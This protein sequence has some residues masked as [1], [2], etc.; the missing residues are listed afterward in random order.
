MLAWPD[1]RYIV[2]VRMLWGLTAKLIGSETMSA[3]VGI[4]KDEMPL[5]VRDA[6]DSGL[7]PLI[8]A[9]SVA[10]SATVTAVIGRGTEPKAFE[11]R[12]RNCVP[13]MDAWMVWR[14]VELR[15]TAPVSFC[16]HG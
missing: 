12:M 11:M 14:I 5:K 10:G 7:T 16:G 2:T 1:S 3:P 6:V 13:P 15:N 4:L 9:T 8:P